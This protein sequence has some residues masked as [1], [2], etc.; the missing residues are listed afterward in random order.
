MYA[1]NNYNRYCT[2]L[3][4]GIYEE[5]S[6]QYEVSD[7]S[8]YDSGN[9][10]I[11]QEDNKLKITINNYGFNGIF[12]YYYSSWKNN[13]NRTKIYSDNIGTFSVGYMQ[14]FVPDTAASTIEDRK[15]TI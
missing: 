3:P 6:S 9:I 15:N 2:G 4:L 13:V 11:V 8:T 12:P 10:K 14:I 7:Y 5:D 1:T